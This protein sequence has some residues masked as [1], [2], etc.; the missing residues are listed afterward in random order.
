M[1]ATSTQRA[2]KLRQ[3]SATVSAWQAQLAM[4]RI[5]SIWMNATPTLVRTEAFVVPVSYAARV[6]LQQ[7]YQFVPRTIVFGVIV[8]SLVSMPSTALAQIVFTGPSVSWRWIV[9]SG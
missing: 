9:P 2:L 8:G 1:T 6:G 5:A 4:D 7:V 3:A